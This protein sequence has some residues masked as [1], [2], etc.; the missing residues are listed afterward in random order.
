V[1]TERRLTC[2]RADLR[3]EQTE[4]QDVTSWPSV[5]PGVRA[6]LHSP[7][8]TWNCPVPLI[9]DRTSAAAERTA[10][11]DARAF[12][13]GATRATAEVLATRLV[14]LV[15]HGE[16]T[17]NVLN[18]VQGQSA[19]PP[20]TARGW[21]QAYD[22]ASILAEVGAARILTSDALRARQ[23]AHVIS[24]RLGLPARRT[25]LLRERHWGVFQGGGMA[26]AAAADSLLLD[27]EPVEAGESRAAVRDRVAV[28]LEA[29]LAA[30]AG[31]LILVTHGDVIAEVVRACSGVSAPRGTPHN[32]SVTRVEVCT[33][34]NRV[35]ASTG[36]G[37]RSSRGC[38]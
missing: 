7:T 36:A 32:G 28:L 20:L 12:P 27:H 4:G 5:L 23:T 35:V 22:A 34:P 11:V 6:L 24:G 2:T 9:G 33:D 15:R 16:S 1:C 14:Y 18:R 19:L 17:W 31:P 38:V 8:M 26:D 13:E 10:G 29:S 37:E 3:T 21:R 30:M 25:P